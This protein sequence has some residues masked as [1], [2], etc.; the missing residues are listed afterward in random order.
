MMS[1]VSTKSVSNTP[2]RC[3]LMGKTV[4]TKDI[5]AKGPVGILTKETLA[6]NILD[7]LSSR[8][9]RIVLAESCTCGL[10]ASTL[11]TIPG[12][13][14]HLCGSA[15]VYRPSTK[16]KWLGVSRKTIENRT[17]E[18]EEVVSEMSIG[19]LKRT[20]EAN[21][22]IGIVGHVGP[23]CPKEKDG[24][25]YI[26]ISR[27][28]NKNKL[29]IKE[30]HTYTLQCVGRSRRQEECVEAALTHLVRILS[31]NKKDKK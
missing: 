21:W 15:V 20:P 27:R 24:L 4:P 17:T 25:V 16:R 18:S 1:K 31:K 6:Q 28:T 23:D 14:N 30:L 26:C 11:G 5:S 12:V 13:S 9:E 22:S 10:V 19:A 29:K 2:G 7:I 8:Q 3:A